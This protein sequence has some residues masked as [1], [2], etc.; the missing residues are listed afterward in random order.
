MDAYIFDTKNIIMRFISFAV[1]LILFS[2]A[3]LLPAQTLS[4][5]ETKELC[6]KLG[7]ATLAGGMSVKFQET[8][9]LKILKKPIE[10][11]GTLKFLPPNY[12][13]RMVEHPR[14]AYTYFDGKLLWMVFPKEKLAERY[15]ADRSKV[16]RDTIEGIAAAIE[17]SNLSKR[18]HIVAEKKNKNY[19]LT[20]TPISAEFKKTVSEIFLTVDLKYR[21]T[22][23]VIIS[24]S[25]DRSHIVLSNEKRV[26]LTPE[27]FTY[28]PESD[29]QISYP[30][31][32]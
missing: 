20:L 27:D 7:T 31:G 6:D 19:H 29:I 32:K 2:I 8:K 17:P 28:H 9:T 12:F 22:E 18:F 16:M 3:P 24:T 15:P 1:T 11:S 10:E 23:V 13:C 14:K 21:P 25:G 4:D 30:L 26:K 5:T